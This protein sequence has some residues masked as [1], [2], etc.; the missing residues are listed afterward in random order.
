MTRARLPTF[1]ELERDAMALEDIA[2]AREATASACQHDPLY[3]G[4]VRSARA[5][6]AL[7]RRVGAHLAWLAARADRLDRLMEPVRMERRAP[8]ERSQAREGRAA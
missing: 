6:A 1:S 5:E 3:A 4:A 2:R 8:V 7:L